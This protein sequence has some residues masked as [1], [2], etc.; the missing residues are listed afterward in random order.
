MS[1]MRE[2]ANI[3]VAEI[4]ADRFAE[5]QE[6]YDEYKAELA[7]CAARLLPPTD[8]SSRG[9]PFRNTFPGDGEGEELDWSNADRDLRD[10]LSSAEG[11][12]F[13]D[14]RAAQARR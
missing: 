4:D 14:L 5:L 10:W 6:I 1:E 8:V 13:K 3:T 11:R 9:V 2:A 12:E 7:D